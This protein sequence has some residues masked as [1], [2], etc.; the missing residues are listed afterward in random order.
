MIDAKFHKSE[1]KTSDFINSF[2]GPLFFETVGIKATIYQVGPKTLFLE[3]LRFD[4]VMAIF[5][6]FG[7]FLLYILC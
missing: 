7:S 1:L 3:I 5:R 6:L 2:M 4:L